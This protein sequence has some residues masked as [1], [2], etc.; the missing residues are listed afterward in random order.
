MK[1]KGLGQKAR[2]GNSSK[3]KV[4]WKTKQ[5]G[6]NV[7]QVSVPTQE[8][9]EWE[10][11]FLLT[12]DQHWDNPKSDW[13]LQLK[14]LKEARERGAGIMSAGDF[15]CLMQG[16]FDRRSSKS[17]IR[18][19]HRVDNYLDAVVN[20]AGDFF[21]P[22]ADLFTVIAVG[23]HEAAIAERYETN[24]IDRIVGVLNDRNG[25]QVYCGGF[26]GWIIFSFK[27][28]NRESSTRIVLHYDHGYGGGGPV[29]KD[30]IQHQRRAVYLPDADIV[31]SGHT[32]DAWQAEF[33]RVRLGQHGSIR[34]DTQ[35]H[36]KIPTYKDDYDIG[37]GGWATAKMGMPPKPLGAWWL[38]FFWCTH[39][40][41]VMYEVIR[42][43]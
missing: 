4:D 30:M 21:S 19:E 7:F 33:T 32:H 35:T 8:K 31:L 43:Q 28:P 11:W 3:K 24:M 27:D 17:A 6:K 37:F 2:Q 5:L 13:N 38:R 40:R 14:H 20:T 26:S 12:S 22:Y 25:S 18:P 34:R 29:T 41:R 42:A 9:K 16:K 10:W 23:N 39:N 15:F 1:S 36:I